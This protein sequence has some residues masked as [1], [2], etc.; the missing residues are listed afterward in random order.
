MDVGQAVLRQPVGLLTEG[1][2]PVRRLGEQELA[3]EVGHVGVGG[4]HED[5]VVVETLAAQEGLEAGG[6][7]VGVGVGLGRGAEARPGGAA[8]GGL[9]DVQEVFI[10]RACGGLGGH[11]VEG[12]PAAGGG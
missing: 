3:A 12:G 2:A 8:V 7:A 5:H 9:V 11:G 10:G 1:G 4:I 6:F